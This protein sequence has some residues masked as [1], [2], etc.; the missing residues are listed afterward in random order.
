MYIIKPSPNLPPHQQSIFLQG[1]SYIIAEKNMILGVW[2]ENT[3]NIEGTAT[4]TIG[5]CQLEGE[6]PIQFLITCINHI[7]SSHP[8]RKIIGPMNGNTWM[9]HRLIVQ[10]SKR[11]SF[12]ME[13]TEPLT[14]LSIFEAAGFETLSLYSSSTIDLTTEQP[15]FSRVEKIVSDQGIT[16]RQINTNEF[17]SDLTKI[18]SLCLSAFSHNFLYTPLPK[19]AFMHSYLSKKELID[20]ELVILA[21]KDESLIGFLFCL[22]DSKP[23][24]VIAKTLATCPKHRTTGLGTLLVAKAHQQAKTKGY[25]ETIHALQHESNSSLRI[26]QRFNAEKFRTYALM[27][28]K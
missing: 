9:K 11:P 8:N 26:S 2:T 15:D 1:A 17:E 13:P 24:T 5:A 21:F 19:E 4:V 6:N 23:H 22:P 16:I 7:N 12:L 3:P 27:I 28:K 14:L 25:K 18:Y 10:T 20:P